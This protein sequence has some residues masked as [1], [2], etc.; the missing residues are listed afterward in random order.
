MEEFYITMLRDGCRGDAKLVKV[1]GQ[2]I[3]GHKYEE[4]GVKLFSHNDGTHWRASEFE[5]G[6]AFA[7]ARKKSDLVDAINNCSHTVEEV[8][9]RMDELV[10]KYG[11]ANV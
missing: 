9:E 3:K 4:A 8:I 5:T 1:P 2:I 7:I 10:R 11:K 6:F